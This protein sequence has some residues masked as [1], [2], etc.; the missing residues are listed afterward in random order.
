[1]YLT[2]LDPK[3]FVS[4]CKD[5]WAEVKKQNAHITSA[6]DDLSASAR[7]EVDQKVSAAV[8]GYL[9]VWP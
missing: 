8:K 2:K 3:A 1:M 9:K 5:Y 4:A 6:Y 7:L